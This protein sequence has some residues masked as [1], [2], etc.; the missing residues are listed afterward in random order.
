[1][2]WAFVSA[3][4]AVVA[5]LL[6]W[7]VRRRDPIRLVRCEYWVYLKTPQLPSQDAI[8]TRMVAEN[9]HTRPGLPC[10]G[11]REGMLFSDIRLHCAV[12]LR[13][14]NPHV[15]RPDVF[16]EHIEP[17][18]EVLEALADSLAVARARYY[19]PTPLPDD[20]H[21]Q[22]LPH[23]A[24]AIASLGGGTVVYDPIGERL[25][26]AEEFFD[27]LERAP[28]ASGPDFHLSVF[29]QAAEPGGFAYTRGLAKVGLSELRTQAA[30]TDQRVLVMDLTRQLALRFW[31]SRSVER[32]VQLTA[33]GD[34]FWGLIEGERGGEMSVR[35]MRVSPS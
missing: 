5:G 31:E 35:F 23:F 12:A 7:R 2:A 15:F 26:L 19:S 10:I 6:W 13:A 24:D 8:L 3:V 17:R 14:K 21:L 29:W 34:A 9:P 11:A 16:H 22:F 1:M 32:E 20:R 30:P 27:A 33:F 18:R 25:W 28:A 4:V